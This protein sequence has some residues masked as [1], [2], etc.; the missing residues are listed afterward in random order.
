MAVIFAN[1]LIGLGS[2]IVQN[3][4]KVENNITIESFILPAR[5]DEVSKTIEASRKT[6]RDANEKL[7]Q[8]NLVLSKAQANTQFSR[9]AYS[10]WLATRSVTQR[11]EQDPEI[12][13][14]TAALD[15]LVGSERSALALVEAQQ[16]IAL[17]ANQAMSGAQ[18]E[19]QALRDGANE[20]FNSARHGQELRVFLYRLM[21]TLPL[22]AVAGWLFV[23]KRKS[24]YWPFVWGSFSSRCSPF[25][26]SWCHTCQATEGWCAM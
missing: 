10:N 11:S 2:T 14:R 7:Q 8:A 18:L 23:K 9:E 5:L 26:S 15:Q 4:P 3:L 22:L 25:S 6:A 1:F 17:D 16:K 21:L 19:M 12:I 13:S 20:Q 24:T